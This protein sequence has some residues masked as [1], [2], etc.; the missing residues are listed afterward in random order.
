MCAAYMIQGFVPLFA[1]NP[2]EAKFGRGEYQASYQRVAIPYRLGLFTLM[3]IAPMGIALVLTMRRGR[4]RMLGLTAGG[5]AVLAASLAKAYAGQGVLVGLLLWAARLRRSSFL[6]CFAILM[7]A[8]PLACIIPIFLDT[9]MG[10][11]G[12]AG[13]YQTDSVISRIVSGTPDIP[14]QLKFLDMFESNGSWTFG[15]TFFGGLVPYQYY[16]NPSIWTLTVLDGGYTDISKTV[17]GGLRLPVSIWGYT[18]FGYLGA[19]IIPFFSGLVRGA[20]TGFCARNVNGHSL[21]RDTL[22]LTVFLTIGEQLTHFY[23]VSLYWIPGTA[24]T[25]WLL[26]LPRLRPSVRGLVSRPV[27]TSGPG[28]LSRSIPQHQS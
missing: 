8:V 6:P 3:Y 26:M 22:F 10:G 23:L 15:R 21:V 11:D 27:I 2:L 18:A 1:F 17:S 20:F 28:R 24:I 14:D 25:I 13:H 9:I 4:L 16:W 19:A 12:F 7:L 5:V